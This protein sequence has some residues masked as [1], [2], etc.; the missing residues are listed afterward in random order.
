MLVCVGWWKDGWKFGRVMEI[1]AAV[2]LCHK[3]RRTT[4]VAHYTFPLNLKFDWKKEAD[5]SFPEHKEPQWALFKHYSH[6]VFRAIRALKARF[7]RVDYNDLRSSVEFELYNLV[8]N[9][10]LQ[11]TEAEILAYLEKKV[12]N[13]VT[14]L[15]R[16]EIPKGKYCSIFEATLASFATPEYILIKEQEQYLLDK[17]KYLGKKKMS[18]IQRRVFKKFEQGMSEREIAQELGVSQPRVN[19]IKQSACKKVEGCYANN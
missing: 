16:L 8:Q 10:D 15:F 4:G 1:A 11:R 14:P 13:N 6:V 17:A 18:E 19:K 12:V 5:F 2:P 7:K 3:M 9:I